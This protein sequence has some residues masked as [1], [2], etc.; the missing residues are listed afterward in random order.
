MSICKCLAVGDQHFT[1]NNR[2]VTDKL[3]DFIIE[4]VELEELDML[5]LLGDIGHYHNRTDIHPHDRIIKFLW[6]LAKLCSKKSIEFFLIIGNHDRENNRDFMTD[7]HFFNSV[8]LWK[9]KVHVIDRTKRYKVNGHSFV[10]VPYVPD[11]RFEEALED[12]SLEG[13]SAI[14]CHQTFDVYSK[15][16]DP[17]LP[18]YRKVISGHVHDYMIKGILT[19]VGAAYPTRHGESL[20]KTVSLFTFSEEGV[21]EKRKRTNICSKTTVSLTLEEFGQYRGYREF[22]DL[23]ELRIIVNITSDEKPILDSHSLFL[24][25]LKKGIQVEPRYLEE[26]R[27]DIKTWDYKPGKTY[28]ESLTETLT[29]TEL[30]IFRKIFPLG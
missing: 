1:E 7:L 20:D 6:I 24:R 30:K 19:Y 25:L 4:E 2:K 13:I 22:P 28:T 18:K 8:K 11:G 23:S 29:E 9:Y 14:F 21:E 10:F 5:V 15:V 16:G 26:K 12:V 17:V 27:Y 3:T